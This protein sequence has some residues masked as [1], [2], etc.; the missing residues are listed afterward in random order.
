[1]S[2][3]LPSAANPLQAAFVMEQHI[4]HYTYYQ[5][6]RRAIENTPTIK[7]R[8]VEVTYKVPGSF[9]ERLPLPRKLRG[10]LTGRAQV[11]QGLYGGCQVAFF[12]TQVP[13]SLAFDSIRRQPYIISTD[14]TPIQYDEMGEQYGHQVEPVGLVRG[15]KHRLNAD[16]FQH[17]AR[18]LP[19]S[20]WVAQSLIKDYGVAT[21][22][23]EV[24]A[25]GVDLDY[26]QP[27]KLAHPEGPC[28]VL[29]VGGDLFRKGGQTLLDA[30]HQLPPGCAELILVT[31]TPFPSEPGV[32]VYNHLGPNTPELLALYQSSDVFVLP[33]CAEAFGIAAVEASA[34]GLPVLASRVGGLQ[35][36]VLN[37]ET[38]Y[39]VQPGDARALAEYLS[40]LCVN[41]AL[42]QRMGQASRERAQ[43][44]FDARKNAARIIE[45]L[46][47]T[48]S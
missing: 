32:T 9:I 20:S 23:I 40:R 21:E 43:N 18:V 8:W 44:C 29:F 15:L 39:L 48:V 3:S 37:D 13:A 41:P 26:W 19:W 1:M 28:R 7:P 24:I 31:R 2:Q 33:S 12:N 22:R 46:F 45:I 27:G 5:N 36:I 16:L 10:S 38:G 6:L 17:A 4:G 11:R 47:E 30:F 14:I 25:P 35:D 34:A 42:R